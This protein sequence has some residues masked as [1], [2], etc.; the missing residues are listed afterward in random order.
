MRKPQRKRRDDICNCGEIRLQVLVQDPEIGHL[1]AWVC[2]T[3]DLL[4]EGQFALAQRKRRVACTRKA[5]SA[6]PN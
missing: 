6:S 3:C 1:R 5:T 4:T 2:S